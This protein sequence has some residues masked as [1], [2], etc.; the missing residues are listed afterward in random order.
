M[1]TNLDPPLDRA[2]DHVLGPEGVPILVEY[3]DF[4][5]PYCREAFGAIKKVL[6]RLEGRV[7]FAFRHLPVA[8]RHPHAERGGRG[9]GRGGR[10]GTVLGDARSPVQSAERLELPGTLAFFVDGERYGGFYDVESLT[11]TLEDAIAA[12][13]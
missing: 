9:G 4:E 2:R 8:A 12:R 1:A 11:W 5:C 7:A 13:G 10:Q 3:G 6:A